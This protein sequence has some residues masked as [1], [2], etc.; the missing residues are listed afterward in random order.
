MSPR[1]PGGVFNAAGVMQ[2][3]ARAATNSPCISLTR[4]Y[5][6]AEDY[7]RNASRVPP[8]SSTPAYVYEIDIANPPPRGV[9][10]IDPLF[11]IASE[12]QNPLNDPSYHHDGNQ[13]FL[14]GVVNAEMRPS[15]PVRFPRGWTGGTSR[16]PN[17]S[18]ELEA[19]VFA[20]RDAEVLV[21]GNLPQSCV[22]DR[23]EVF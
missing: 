10:V 7:A 1:R 4:S 23:H 5:G 8:T 6:A 12:N 20:L 14:L 11:L 2:H 3:I 15:V 21:L 16:L 22:I 17:L 18:V 19:M 9:S 13:D